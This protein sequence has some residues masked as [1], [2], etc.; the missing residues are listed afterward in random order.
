MIFEL[1]STGCGTN[2]WYI[3]DLPNP[4]GC[5]AGLLATYEQELQDVKV[6]PPDM[7][8]SLG[9]FIHAGEYTM[10]LKDGNIVEVEVCLK[11]Y[12]KQWP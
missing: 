11:L 5:Y 12:V 4:N 7:C 3:T 8:D 1:L 9:S 10:K 6:A 2:S